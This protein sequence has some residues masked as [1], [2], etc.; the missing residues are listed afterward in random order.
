MKKFSKNTPEQIVAKL[1]QIV[2][3]RDGGATIS[4]ACREVGISEAT[5]HHWQREYGAMSRTKAREFK[6]LRDRVTRLERLLGQAELEKA[7]MR[8][9]CRSKIL[10]PNRRHEGRALP[11]ITGV[12]TAS[13][14]SGSQA[15]TQLVWTWS[16][17][18]QPVITVG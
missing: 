4:Q 10:S 1:E 9:A 5:F 2:T 7:A 18:G 11:D 13:G 14:L 3:L 16:Y 6:A 17:Y 12:Y 8:G 15:I